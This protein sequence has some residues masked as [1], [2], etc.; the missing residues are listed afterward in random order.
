MHKV[1][2]GIS[3]KNGSLIWSVAHEMLGDQSV[4]T[5]LWTQ[6]NLLFYSVAYKGGSRLLR[7]SRQKGKTEAQELWFNNKMRI[8]HGNAVRVG[9]QIYGSSGDFGPAFMTAIDVQ[10]GNILW[11]DRSYPKAMLLYA[12]G[13]F[14]VL[15][16]DGNLSLARMDRQGL[17]II[18][19]VELL[20]NNAWTAPSLLGTT[21]YVRDRTRIMALDLR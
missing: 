8:H 6:D 17:K 1:I 14:I 7:L 3:P 16:E 15:D 4:F 21:L 19:K 11:Q 13:K 2:A 5:P 10:S 9:G 20:K 12:D 18:S